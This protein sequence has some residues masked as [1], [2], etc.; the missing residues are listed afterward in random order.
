LH[1]EECGRTYWTIF[2]KWADVLEKDDELERV[3]VVEL[4]KYLAKDSFKGLKFN[5]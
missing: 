2:V 1:L 4:K 3:V 5:L